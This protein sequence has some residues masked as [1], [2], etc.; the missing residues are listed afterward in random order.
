VPPFYFFYLEIELF[1]YRHFPG[2]YCFIV[3]NEGVDMPGELLFIRRYDEAK[4]ALQNIVDM[5]DR[6]INNMFLF[7]HQNHGAF[8]E[9]RR[10]QFKELTNVEIERMQKA[11]REVFEM[12]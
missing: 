10:E 4:K 3:Y 2:D 6:K 8:P 11:Y 12:D 1:D 7:L 5:P 9:R